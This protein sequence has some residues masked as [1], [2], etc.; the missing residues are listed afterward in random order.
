[1]DN[2]QRYQN[3]TEK[4][5]ADPTTRP[6]LWSDADIQEHFTL[7]T[8]LGTIRGLDLPGHRNW[9]VYQW[10]EYAIEVG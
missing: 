1:M 3:L 5:I 7:A 2:K 9:L 4:L 8:L 10:E 6:H